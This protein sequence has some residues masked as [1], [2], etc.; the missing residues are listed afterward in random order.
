[1]LAA[2]GGCWLMYYSGSDGG[3]PHD[4]IGRGLSPDGITWTQA[5][6]GQPGDVIESIA[7]DGSKFLAVGYPGLTV[8]GTIG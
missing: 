1:M 2:P 7:F 4:V 5:V 6:V 8:E 3:G